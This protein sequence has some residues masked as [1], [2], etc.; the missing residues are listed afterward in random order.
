MGQ[1][2]V[3]AK[4]GLL[5]GSVWGLM[6]ALGF[7]AIVQVFPDAWTAQL[8][9]RFPPGTFPEEFLA[10]AS[11]LLIVIPLIL[12]IVVGPILG[13]IFSAIHDKYLKSRRIEYRGIL[14]S[15]VL[16]LVYDVLDGISSL[17]FGLDYYLAGAGLGFLDN[18]VFGF[19]M[20]NLYQRFSRVAHAPEGL[21]K[22]P[23]NSC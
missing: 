18:L 23:A 22:A 10:F 20:G 5:A 12:G 9:S 4:S 2:G 14:F 3:G 17:A 16:W 6:S 11:N 13:M 8:E 15:L 1:V 7:Y 19:L 21:A